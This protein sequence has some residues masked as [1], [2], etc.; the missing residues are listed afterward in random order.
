MMTEQWNDIQYVF[1]FYWE[2]RKDQ[3]GRVPYGLTFEF[4]ALP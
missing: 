2:V 1:D 3:Y 4:W